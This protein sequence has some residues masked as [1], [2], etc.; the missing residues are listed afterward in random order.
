[1]LCST[2]LAVGWQLGDREEGVLWALVRRGGGSG[3]DS[4]PPPHPAGLPREVL[5]LGG[6]SMKSLQASA[7]RLASRSSHPFLGTKMSTAVED[8]AFT[9]GRGLGRR[10]GCPPG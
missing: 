3:A 2:V 5:G 4:P 10:R 1:M 7:V 9:E 8:S 6:A